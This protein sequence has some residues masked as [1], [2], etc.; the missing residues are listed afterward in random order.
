MDKQY[1]HAIMLVDA[2]NKGEIHRYLTKPWNDDDLL[3]LVQQALQQYELVFENR[4]LTALTQK[5]NEALNALN[6]GLE[7]KVA[8]ITVEITQKNMELNEINIKLEKSFMDT[9][10]LLSSFINPNL[11]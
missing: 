7:K 1:E 3:L 9:V 10:R 11:R 6:Q 2:V 8:E 4:L 5:Q